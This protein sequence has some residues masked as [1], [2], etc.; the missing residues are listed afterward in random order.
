MSLCPPVRPNP[1]QRH[2]ILA[3]RRHEPSLHGRFVISGGLCAPF[4]LGLH[5][6]RHLWILYIHAEASTCR[7]KQG[8]KGKAH[9]RSAHAH[10]YQ[11]PERVWILHVMRLATLVSEEPKPSAAPIW[12]RDSANDCH[13][14]KLPNTSWAGDRGRSWPW[15]QRNVKIRSA[16]RGKPERGSTQDSRGQAGRGERTRREK[17]HL[18]LGGALELDLG[19]AHR[20]TRRYALRS[21]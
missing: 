18:L 20:Q 7:E 16:V 10:L 12:R 9:V 19:H 21:A 5:H 14:R 4:S 8:E 17:T 1:H 2:T 13:N 15:V 3:P 6:G 11:S